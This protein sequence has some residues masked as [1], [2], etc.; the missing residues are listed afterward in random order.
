MIMLQSY[1]HISLQDS[2][3]PFGGTA[4]ALD[5]KTTKTFLF[6]CMLTICD[7]QRLIRREAF[8]EEGWKK[9]YYLA[10][11]NGSEMRWLLP[12]MR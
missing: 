6:L 4:V 5:Y 2:C 8:S 12:F 3:I 11:G 1:K 9:L 10:N 7:R